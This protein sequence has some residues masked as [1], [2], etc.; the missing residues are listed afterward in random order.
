MGDTEASLSIEGPMTKAD[1]NRILYGLRIELWKDLHNCLWKKMM[2]CGTG[3]PHSAGGL[4]LD[5]PFPQSV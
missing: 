3:S 5:P 1:M 2:S 4:P